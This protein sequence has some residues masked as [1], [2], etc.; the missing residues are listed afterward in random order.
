M[1]AIWDN[2][3]A[4]RS[5]LNHLIAAGNLPAA[6]LAWSQ[7]VA[8]PSADD[9][10]LANS[11]V[12]FLLHQQAWRES[13]HAWSSWLGRRRGDY[14]D[15]NL[16][17]NGRFEFDPSG[18]PLDW[19]MVIG[20]RF[21]SVREAHAARIQFAGKSNVQFDHLW[22]TAVL[23][24]PGTYR[25]SARVKSEG[26]STNEGPRLAVTDL[27]IASEPFT[28]TRGWTPVNLEFGVRQPRSVRIAV[29]RQPSWK[30]DNKINGSFWITDV[31]LVPIVGKKPPRP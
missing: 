17:V 21:E 27:G 1:G 29:V 2:R 6:Q 20:E 5:W 3:R 19:H 24:V 16:I 8:V 18:S 26:I 11:Y 9:A 25:L 10:A 30:F 28:G 15:K 12:D 31:A 7:V 4:L 22:Q 13:V 14:P 23:L